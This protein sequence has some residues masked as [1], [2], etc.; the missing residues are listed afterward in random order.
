MT[1]VI[2]LGPN[3]EYLGYKK[4]KNYNKASNWLKNHQEL[5]IANI[6]RELSLKDRIKLAPEYF[7]FIGRF[8]DFEI[9]EE[10]DD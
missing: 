4:F 10:D 8:E 1:I 6:E 5:M 3:D 7:P 2:L 9:I